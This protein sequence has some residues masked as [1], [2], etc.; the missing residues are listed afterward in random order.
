[1]PK[2]EFI[3]GRVDKPDITWNKN[4]I[5]LDGNPVNLYAS[6]DDELINYISD[7]LNWIEAWYPNGSHEKGLALYGYSIIKESENLKKFRDIIISWR[8]LFIHAPEMILLTGDCGWDGES[9]KKGYYEKNKFKKIDIIDSM[10]DLAEVIEKALISGEY[11][12]H[13]G[14]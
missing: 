8:N 9:E 6:I 7:S 10:D 1:M 4:G 12:I 3:V 11:V 5:L 13:C 2:H 14:I